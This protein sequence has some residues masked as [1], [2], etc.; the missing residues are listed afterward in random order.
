LRQ[1]Q[2]NK[3]TKEITIL[4]LLPM[5]ITMVITNMPNKLYTIQL[6]SPPDN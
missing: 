6:F 5:I 1:R 2:F 4:L 3:P